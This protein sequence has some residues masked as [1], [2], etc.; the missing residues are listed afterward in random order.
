MALLPV[1]LCLAVKE[2]VFISL[3]LNNREKVLGPLTA[4]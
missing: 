4:Q 1:L 3:V 2:P